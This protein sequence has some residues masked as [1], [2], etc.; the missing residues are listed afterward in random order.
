MPG[1]TNSKYVILTDIKGNIPGTEG[2]T[3]LIEETDKTAGTY[4][5][6]IESEGY[7]NMSLHLKGSG[8]VTFT[9]FATNDE[10]ADTTADTGWVDVTNSIIGGTNLVDDEGIYFVDTP[11]LPLKWMVKYVT[12]DATNAVDAWIIKY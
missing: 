2:A 12:S 8:G 6:E 9:L 7:K 11:Q 5:V 1:A 3:H 4:R 10:T